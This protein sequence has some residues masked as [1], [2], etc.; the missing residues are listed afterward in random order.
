MEQTRRTLREAMEE[1]SALTHQVA[2]ETAAYFRR[3]PKKAL[4]EA[5]RSIALDANDPAGHLAMANALLK[6]GKPAEAAESMHQAMRLDPYY[7]ASYLT[8]LGRAQFAMGQF[9]DAAATL[10]RAASR[11]PNDDW[12]FVRSCRRA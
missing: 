11:N 4:T 9:Q 5:E 8:R 1:P 6:A 3:Q 12:T 2:S 7:P 10:E